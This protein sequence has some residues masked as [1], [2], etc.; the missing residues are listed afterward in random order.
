MNVWNKYEPTAARKHGKSGREIRP[1]SVTIDIHSHIAVPAAGAYV[2]KHAN[3]AGTGLDKFMS[4]ET[5]AVDAKQNED[6]KTRIVEFEPRLRNLDA[7]GI[8]M[9]VIKPPPGQCYYTVPADIAVKSA[10]IVNDGIAEYSRE[11]APPFHP[12][13]HRAAAL[14][15]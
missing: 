9:Q 12:V 2:A 13:R 1:Q 10:Q 15:R 5:A 4:P 6:M 8:D 14:R 3:L 11:V 7:M